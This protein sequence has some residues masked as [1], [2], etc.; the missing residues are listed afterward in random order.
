MIAPRLRLP[1]T[2]FCGKGGVGKTTL[3]LSYALRHASQGRPALDVSSHPLSELAVSVSLAGLKSGHPKA[4]ANLF[5][6]HIDPREILHQYVKRQI[7]SEMLADAVLSSK[8]YQSLIDVAPG[9]KEMVFLHRLQ[10]L[11]EERCAPETGEQA[12]NK[13]DLVVW[14]A[15]S[16]G[17]F[18]Q[19]LEVSRHFNLYLS[20][21][22]AAMGKEITE[23]FSV[24]EN[25]ALLPVTTLEE[26]AIEETLELCEKL[27]EK[28]A[29][30]PRGVVC[31][32]TS[33]VLR[34]YA[35]GEGSF[36]R[37]P[38]S[39]TTTWQFILDR[40]AIERELFDRLRGA[41]N[42]KWNIVE[43]Q[44]RSGADLDLLFSLAEQLGQI[45]AEN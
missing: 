41:K 40:L 22:F 20:G 19:T 9:L 4:A 24:A 34:G 11:A 38:T 7:P 16:T 25:Y 23:F 14:D 13:Y 6:I 30:H 42:S 1:L 36:P 10:Q 33:P 43:R 27:S 29:M 3:A 35:R 8:I 39:K 12:V 28:L 31:N 15:P 17:H 32:M 5:V 44:P 18:L 26:M 2:I 45:E 21:P 37:L